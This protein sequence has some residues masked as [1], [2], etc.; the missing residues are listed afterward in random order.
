MEIQSYVLIIPL[1]EQHYN[2]LNHIRQS[3]PHVGPT[4][5]E[6][7][8]LVNHAALLVYVFKTLGKASTYTV[9]KN[10]FVSS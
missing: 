1:L 6:V 8:F 9:K 7:V 3:C 5:V 10:F 4:P 2:N